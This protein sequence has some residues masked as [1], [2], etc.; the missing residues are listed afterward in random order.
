[1]ALSREEAEARLRSEGRNEVRIL[2]AKTAFASL[3]Q[4]VSEPMLLLLF[5]GGGLYW[6]IGEARDALALLSFVVLVVTISLVQE[7]RTAHAV[8]K[9]RALSEPQAVVVRDG[10]RVRVPGREV[11]CGDEVV[12]AEGDRVPADGLLLEATHLALDES[13][14]TGESFPVRKRSHALEF[15][16]P[17]GLEAPGGDGQSSVFCGSLVVR[18]QGRFEVFATGKHTQVGRIGEALVTVETQRTPLERE[19][20]RVV[21]RIAA[22]AVLLCAAVVVFVGVARGAWLQGALIGLTLAMA[23][24]PEE[25]PVVL[26]LFHA[27][28][29]WRVAKH[30]VLVRH[31][32]ALEALGAAT[33][34]CADKTGT[35]TQNQMRIARLELPT[36][37]QDVDGWT[38]TLSE[39]FHELVEVGVLASARE[40][41][42]PMESAFHALSA[43]VLAGSEHQHPTWKPLRTYP[44]STELLAMTYAY[45]DGG[46][47]L[48]A[49]K[50][51]P[52]AVIDLCHL[53]PRDAAEVTA[54]ASRLAAWGMRV[55]GIARAEHRSGTLPDEQHAFDFR[56]L[57][58]VGLVDP[59]R[60]GVPEAVRECQRAG[61]RVLMLTGDYPETATAI[62]RTI[63]LREGE[64]VTGSEVA[65]MSD[66]ALRRIAQRVSVFARMVPEQKLRLVRALTAEGEVVA[67][68]GDGV[69]DAPALKAA[70]IGIAMGRRG[71]D[72]AREAAALVLTDDDFS[73]I[74]QAVRQGRCIF[75]NLQKSLHYVLAA[76]IPIA[77]LSLLP[78]ALRWPMVLHPIHVAF[79]EL[80]IAPV[81]SIAFE[82]EAAEPDLM[83]RPP[84]LRTAPLFER[85]LVLASVLQGGS[86]LALSF[87]VFACTRASGTERARALAFVCLMGCN[88]ALIV[89]NRSRVR[90]A[91][92]R[93]VPSNPTAGL[94]AL[95]ALGVLGMVFGTRSLRTAF[96][97][98]ELTVLEFVG[99][100]ACGLLALAWLEFWKFAAQRH[101]A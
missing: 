85:R 15:G 42:D 34:L 5:V 49:T 8:E 78:V 47:F 101:G 3:L 89:T 69:N 100:L 18:G 9:L 17:L 53:A 79:V 84:R 44:L 16:R 59:V 94:V 93:S 33:I 21:Q 40:P 73:S 97:F 37:G 29:A 11:V 96:A 50:G 27:L 10:R 30:N 92:S 95:S 88:V 20:R 55:L 13:M 57:G 65:A 67:M 41:T 43:K 31:M 58:L 38:E 26:T 72:V 68:T 64:T 81:C 75:D 35:L 82:V 28:G 14:L 51:A 36:S 60:Q 32:P 90:S 19:V 52:E 2:R 63:G 24:L 23:L 45:R 66:A 1:M 71:T 70:T 48:A 39:A 25:L 54:Q 91:I 12:L 61:V 83:D 87:I 7:R 80:V 98:A 56:F 77:G 22:G 74:V 6:S 86:V 99:A 62:G 46:R 76:H 4:V